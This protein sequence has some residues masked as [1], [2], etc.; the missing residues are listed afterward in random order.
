MDG[1]RRQQSTLRF[2]VTLFLSFLRL[3][4]VTLVLLLLTTQ[5]RRKGETKPRTLK[6]GR[7]FQEDF[8][9]GSLWWTLKALIIR[10][11]SPSWDLFFTV[12]IDYCYARKRKGLT[13]SLSYSVTMISGGPLLSWA[14][15]ITMPLCHW[16]WEE[17]QWIMRRGESWVGF[18]VGEGMRMINNEPKP[19]FK[20]MGIWREERGGVNWGP[21]RRVIDNPF[22][23]NNAR[24]WMVRQYLQH[25]SV[26]HTLKRGITVKSRARI[27][28]ISPRS[29]HV[30]QL[31]SMG[32]DCVNG[33]RPAMSQPIGGGAE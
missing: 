1:G 29:N 7:A 22:E 30:C 33:G 27:P 12:S 2:K 13:R 3:E 19:H 26:S 14:Q 4:K 5:F 16:W 32:F 17:A 8:G 31:Y 20:W 6:I 15:P 25:E 28:H 24:E 9:F 23:K 10:F 21:S 11:N 18:V